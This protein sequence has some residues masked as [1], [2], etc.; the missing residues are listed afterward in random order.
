MRGWFHA[1]ASVVALILTILLIFLTYQDT[2]KMISML[3]FGLTTIELYTVSAVY[4]IGHWNERPRKVLRSIDHANIFL[5][6]AGTYTPICFNVL[7]DGWR[8]GMLITIWTLAIIG[9]ITAIFTSKLPRWLSPLF[10]IAMGWVVLIALPPIASALSWPIVGLLA[11]GGVLYTIG[12]IIY[13][14]RWPDPYPRVF[15]FHE[16]FHLFT[17]AGGMTFALV[18]LYWVV[19]YIR[20]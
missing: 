13:G 15:G 10:Y 6:I 12:A 16:I 3:I 4:H 17:I 20:R 9:L 18:V 14:K 7:T 1:I 19:P 11:L 8:W 5:F 2:P